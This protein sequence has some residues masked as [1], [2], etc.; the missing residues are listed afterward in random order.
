MN[1]TVYLRTNKIN[2][3]Q[4]VGQS[5]DFKK[6]E[7]AWKCLSARYANKEIQKDRENFGIDNFSL[8]ILALCDTQEESWELEKKYIEELNTRHPNGYNKAYGG[9]TNKGGNEGKH[10]GKEFE[11]GHIPWNKGVK[12][13]H[14]SI[15]TEFKP[16]P[17][18]QLKNGKF[19]K[20]Y[21]SLK[22]ADID[23]FYHSAISACCKG[24]RKSHKG[25][26]WMY[27]SDYEK[28]L[29]NQS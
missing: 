17:I 4:Y 28:M 8:D 2:G 27:K 26:E 3:K 11:K 23:G 19:V 21:K 22:D 24:K 1:Y 9:K 7:K 6:R 10:N 5:E 20:E 15:D 12:G 14:F 25:F 13:L 29:G 18:V 16:I